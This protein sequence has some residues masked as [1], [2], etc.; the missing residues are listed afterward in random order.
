MQDL[1]I[2]GSQSPMCI[3]MR[4]HMH[5][6]MCVC[7]SVCAWH[8]LL[9]LSINSFLIWCNFNCTIGIMDGSVLSKRH[10]LYAD[11]KGNA[12]LAEKKHFNAYK[13]VTR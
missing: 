3:C 1:T 10:A 2:A 13:S 4:T 5:A 12:V 7:I 11:A 8:I 9:R 6:C